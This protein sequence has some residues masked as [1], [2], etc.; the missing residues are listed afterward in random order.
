MAKSGERRILVPRGREARYLKS[1]HLTYVH[2]GTLFAVPFDLGAMRVLGGAVAMETSVHMSAEDETGSAGYD[3]SDEGILVFAP[4]SGVGAAS[5]TRLLFQ[6][7]Q[8]NETPLPVDVRPYG[9]ALLSPDD[10]RV[11]A[12]INDIEGTH[13]WVLDVDRH[14]VQR[15]TSTGQD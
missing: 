12:H 11:A 10:R 13:V 15:L 2:A 8:G 14:S 7:Q 9:S 3:V 4:P 6:D 5:P 1:G